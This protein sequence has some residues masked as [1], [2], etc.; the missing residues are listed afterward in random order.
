MCYEYYPHRRIKELWHLD[1]PAPVRL[2]PTLS[3]RVPVPSD[4]HRHLRAWLLFTAFF[5]SYHMPAAGTPGSTSPHSRHS[6][7]V[8]FEE[9]LLFDSDSRSLDPTEPICAAG[10]L[11]DTPVYTCIDEK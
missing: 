3:L 9:I 7:Q 11:T 10:L 6:H 8:G 5:R 2:S 4:I 1:V